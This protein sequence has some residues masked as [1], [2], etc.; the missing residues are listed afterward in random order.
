MRKTVMNKLLLLLLGTAVAALQG[1][2]QLRPAADAV[3]VY[4]FESRDTAAQDPR[5]LVDRFLGVRD[6]GDLYRSDDST[7]HYVSKQDVSETFEYDPA[8]GNFTFNK[9]MKKYKGSFV[10]QLPDSQRSVFLA[11]EFLRTNGIAPRD[12]NQLKLVHLGGVRS[13]TVV[14]GRRAGPVIDELATVN[15]GRVVDGIPVIGPGS[16]IVVNVGDRGEIMGVI[17][18]WRELDHTTRVRVPAEQLLPAQEAQEMA[19]RQIMAEFGEGTSYRVL[20]SSRKYYDNNG[21]LLQP[22]YAFEVTVTLRDPKVKPFDYLCVIPAL[23]SS[24]EP[25]NLTAVD[26]AAKRL[27]GIAH[28][29]SKPPSAERGTTD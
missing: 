23:R 2:A 28:R 11:E 25:L 5:A 7:L 3:N 12:F 17:R 27:I 1:C 8:T 16:K 6:V 19:R 26:P 24:D 10:P 22:V 29:D 21:R 4:T 9:S 18:R 14:D 20:A 13:T 15:F